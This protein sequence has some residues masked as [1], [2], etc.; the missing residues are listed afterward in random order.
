VAFSDRE[1]SISADLAR[2]KEARD[3]AARAASEFGLPAGEL[4]AVKLAMSEAVT[5]AIQHGSRSREDRIRIAALEEGGSLIFEV[6]DSGQFRPV[7]DRSGEIPEGG[8]GLDFMRQIMDDVDLRPGPQ[9]TL[10]RFSKRV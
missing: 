2:L 6:E 9:G 3:F 1:H 8:R 5:N 4:H 10:L 7:V